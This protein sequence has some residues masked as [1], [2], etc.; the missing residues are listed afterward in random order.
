VDR[1]SGFSPSVYLLFEKLAPCGRSKIVTK[2]KRIERAIWHCSSKACNVENFLF[3]FRKMLLF[4]ESG[5]VYY[6]IPGE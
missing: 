4:N 5:D 6:E 3:L 1:E 2:T